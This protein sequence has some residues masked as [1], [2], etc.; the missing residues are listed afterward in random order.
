MNSPDAS[1]RIQ[2]RADCP[3]E[4]AALLFFD[5]ETTGLRP[6]RRGHITEIA[7]LDREG[8]RLDWR[9]MP[10]NADDD[11]LSTP[12]PAL[13]D[14]LP[15]GVVVGHNVR[16]DLHVIA[17]AADRRGLRGP[18]VRFIDT[19][20]LAHTLVDDV[21]DYRLETLVDAFD[22]AP[23]GAFH[24]ALGDARAT[25]ALF[26]KLVDVGSLRTLGDAGLK[27]LDWSTF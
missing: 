1:R 4:A 13:F 11:R 21:V 19:L 6:D 10:G 18:H 12:L 22:L 15:G 20:G 25:R 27:R 23:D 7:L 5:I 14:L 8:V 9:R 3:I 26:W 24:T 16:F 2:Q 17:Y